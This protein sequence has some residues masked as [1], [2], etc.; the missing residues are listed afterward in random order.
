MAKKSAP[1]AVHEV[2]DWRRRVSFDFGKG[3][4]KEPKEFSDLAVDQEVT[5]IVK[6][7]INSFNKSKDSSSFSLLMDSV[8]L[9]PVQKDDLEDALKT[10]RRKL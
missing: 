4:M 1:L 2:D 9:H 7:K 10:T 5:V 6:G 3:G 8:E